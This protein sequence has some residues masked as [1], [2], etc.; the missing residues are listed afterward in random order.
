MSDPAPT[1]PQRLPYSN[2]GGLAA[3]GWFALLWNIVVWVLFLGGPASMMRDRHELAGGMV[4]LGLLIGVIMLVNLGLWIARYRR[5]GTSWLIVNEGPVPLGGVLAGTVQCGENLLL[6]ESA[7]VSL[8][9]LRETTTHTAKGGTIVSQIALWDTSYEVSI[10]LLQAQPLP[11][12]FTLPPDQPA[13]LGEKGQRT[14]WQI[15]VTAA[16]KGADYFARWEIPVVAAGLAPAAPPPESPLVNLLAD[17]APSEVLRRSRIQ[18]TKALGGGTRWYFPP[19]SAH[20]EAP[21]CLIFNIVLLGLLILLAVNEA[22]P[23]LIAGTAL[24][25]LGA[26]YVLGRIWVGS[27]ELVVTPRQ[28]RFR[29]GIPGLS[30]IHRHPRESIGSLK[31]V[32]A[33]TIAGYAHYRL[34]A[35]VKGGKQVYLSP[36]LR[37]RPRIESLKAS[38]EAELQG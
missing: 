20:T 24:A 36:I 17:P 5:F 22:P 25:F 37:G 23:A 8:T 10:D 14:F 33:N 18:V 32:I 4:L 38:V 7:E 6:S 11:V 15:A 31:L 30:M 2:R 3:F 27:A 9:C 34:A 1:T 28:I 35:L 21:G 19:D 26:L 16:R 29:N 13:T 12:W